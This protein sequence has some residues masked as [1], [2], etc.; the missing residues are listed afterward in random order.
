M[1]TYLLA[2]L[3]ASASAMCPGATPCSGHGV[4]GNFDKCTCYR[5]W[6]GNDCADRTCPFATGWNYVKQQVGTSSF[7]EH[8][9]AECSNKGEC[10]RKTGECKCFDGYTGSACRRMKCEDD[11]NNHG[12][13]ETLKRVTANGYTGWDSEK[14]QKCVCD[15]GFEG[16]KCEK[17]MCK[18]GDDPMTLANLVS[19]TW[20]AQAAESQSMAFASFN[21]GD[22][23][24]LTYTDWR[25][26]KWTTWPLDAYA[27][28]A[29]MV[30]E[31]LEALPNEAIPSVTVSGSDL[32]S[33]SG[34][35]VVTF[36][37]SL[38]SGNQNALEV[39]VDGCSLDGCQPKFADPAG[40]VTITHTDG[41][42][43]WDVC[44]NRGVCNADTGD[45]ECFGGFTGEACQI[46]TIIS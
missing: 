15:P 3:F 36:S 40:T 42:T 32:S 10:D 2:S 18:K 31:A 38:N 5:N 44:S 14:I 29:I 17:K 33:G 27:G 35:L 46:Q 25:G 4:C 45:C 1:R 21:S 24:T 13:C 28:T 19:G 23:V 34:T 7:Y 41:T 11:C 22:K 16:D 12:T 43:E 20:A 9:Y 37:S 30:E 6:Q 26:E 8:T 39:N